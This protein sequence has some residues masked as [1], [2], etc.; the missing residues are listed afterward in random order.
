MSDGDG[1]QLKEFRSWYV[2]QAEDFN[3]NFNLVMKRMEQLENLLIKINKRE[4]IIPSDL[5]FQSSSDL[6]SE[7]SEK[8]GRYDILLKKREDIEC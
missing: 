6:L 3:Y 7:K 5:I 2:F 4:T 8:S 1:F